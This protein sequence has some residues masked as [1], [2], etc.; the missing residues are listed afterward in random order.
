VELLIIDSKR[1]ARGEASS[2]EM[3]AERNTDTAA[4]RTDVKHIASACVQCLF[5][6]EKNPI[7][8]APSTKT[9]NA[10][11]MMLV[12][13]ITSKILYKYMIYHKVN[14]VKFCRGTSG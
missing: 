3:R 6:E 7:K 9:K 1:D 11:E 12:S 14:F 8:A 4:E 13:I 2:H 5:E 10:A